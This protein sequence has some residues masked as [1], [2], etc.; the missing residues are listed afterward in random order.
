MGRP[1]VWRVYRTVAGSKVLIMTGSIIM[2]AGAVSISMA[3]P[4]PSE[5]ESWKSA[6]HRRL[7]TL[8]L[9]RRRCSHADRNSARNHDDR[10]S[11][12]QNLAAG[13]QSDKLAKHQ[14]APRQ[15]PKLIRVRE[16]NATPDANVLRR[17][18]LEQVADHP[19]ESSDKRPE[20]HRPRAIQLSKQRPCATIKN[21]SQTRTLFPVRQT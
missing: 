1:G 2:I 4:P 5:M 8:H 16:R 13:R 11:H 21:P 3:A 20:Q 14:G 9:R 6:M 19:A 18:L 15:S 12:D 7:P 10:S 17:V